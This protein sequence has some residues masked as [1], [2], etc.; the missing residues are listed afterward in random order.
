MGEFTRDEIETAW[1]EYQKRGVQEHDWPG[2]AEMFTDDA[3]YMPALFIISF[4]HSAEQPQP[5]L[6]YA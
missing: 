3:R 2:W 1:A 4:I 6:V 5:A